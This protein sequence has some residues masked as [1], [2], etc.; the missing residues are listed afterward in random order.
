MEK[1][2]DKNGV[3]HLFQ[4]VKTQIAKSKKEVL[5]TK[6]KANGIASL[7]AS[8]NVPLSQLGNVDTTLFEIVQDL[9]TTELT[10][11]QKNHIFI[12]PRGLEGETDKNVYKEYIYTGPDLQVSERYWEELGEFTSETD[13]KPYAK[14]EDTVKWISFDYRAIGNSPLPNNTYLSV[15]LGNNVIEEVD[16]P[17]VKGASPSDPGTPGFMSSTDKYKLDKIDVDA[18][19][20]SITNANTAASNTN[21]AISKAEQATAEAEK[22][23]ATFEGT[24]LTVT[25]R[26]GK[27][28]SADL[29]GEKG[30]Q[31]LKG[32]KGDTG[33]ATNIKSI[34]ATIDGNIGTPSVQITSTGDIEKDVTFEFRN[35]KG[36]K[37]TY[38]ELTDSEKSQISKPATDAANELNKYLDIV[39]LPV[40]ETQVE[41]TEVAMDANKVYDIKVG[42]TLTLTLNPPTDTSVTNEYQWS[43]DTGETAPTVTFPASVIWIDT[44]S[45]EANMHYEFNIRYTGGKYYGLYSNWNLLTE[46]EEA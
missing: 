4:G 3:T 42:D 30:D 29:K 37:M 35:L 6:G 8:G 22:V 12:V 9:P 11:Q 31:G 1:Y 18:L 14:K 45:V 43:F 10:E 23:N 32:D 21:A 19:T 13:L 46:E 16:V 40:V 41:N 38:A 7:D 15:T 39:K 17:L 5:D 28:T 34:S 27:S 26:N 25:D 33:A 20:T 24:T 44:P 2:L 36:E